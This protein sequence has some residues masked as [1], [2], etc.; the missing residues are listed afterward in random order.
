VVDI[1]RKVNFETET[2]LGINKMLVSFD[3]KIRLE[4][5]TEIMRIL[6]SGH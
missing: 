4:F 6:E 3:S 1:R 5:D 2:T